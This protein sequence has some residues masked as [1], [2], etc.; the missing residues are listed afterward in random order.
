MSRVVGDLVVDELADHL[1]FE[2][3]VQDRRAKA[4][5]PP[6][7]DCGDLPGAGHLLKGFRMDLQE[8]CCLLAV[9]E[10]LKREIGGFRPTNGL[11]LEFGHL[12]LRELFVAASEL[13]EQL[14]STF[15]KNEESNSF[16]D[17]RY[18]Q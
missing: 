3:V 18:E 11:G 10:P 16:L 2:P 1:V 9:Q 14:Q 8:S 6:D 4:P 13:P 17:R 15:G 12:R 7:L 5:E